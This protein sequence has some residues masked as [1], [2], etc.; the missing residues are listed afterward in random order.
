[1]NYRVA[2]V[3]VVPAN[4]SEDDL[5]YLLSL[6][7]GVHGLKNEPARCLQAMNPVELDSPLPQRCYLDFFSEELAEARRSPEFVR[8]ALLEQSIL[9][10]RAISI[11]LIQLSMADSAEAVSAYAAAIARLQGE[12]RRNL[13][14]LGELPLDDNYIEPTKNS[15]SMDEL[16]EQVL[17][18]PDSAR[19]SETDTEVKIN[20]DTEM[21]SKPDARQFVSSESEEPTP[22]RGGPTQLG[23]TPGPYRYRPPEAQG[24]D[25]AAQAVDQGLRPENASRESPGCKKRIPRPDRVAAGASAGTRGYDSVDHQYEGNSKMSAELVS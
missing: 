15:C 20:A 25:P 24:S 12:L 3:G 11:L 17:Q 13:R 16:I 21:D 9:A 5:R 18:P 23:K 19:G 7:A 22:G 2:S 14:S 6:R 10:K 8:R 4:A 1:M